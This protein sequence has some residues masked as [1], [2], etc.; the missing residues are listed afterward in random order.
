MGL[1]LSPARAQNEIVNEAQYG[2]TISTNGDPVKGGTKSTVV[3]STTRSRLVDPRGEVQGCN[4]ATL[5]NYTGF[6][7]GL[8]DADDT[9]PTGNGVKSLVP[10]TA[11]TPSD[12]ADP[13]LQNQNPYALTNATHGLFSFLLDPSRGQIAPGKTYL[14]ILQPP[15]GSAYR[16][17]RVRIVMQSA[18]AGQV[19]YTAASLDGEAISASSGSNSLVAATM[20]MSVSV[21]HPA[22]VG[23]NLTLSDCQMHPL[24]ITKIGDRAAAEPGDTVVYRVAVN[25]LSGAPL[26]N[27]Q[28]T[29]T[30]PEGF[31]FQDK[32]LRGAQADK[33]VPLKAVH[34]GRS[35]TLTA[36]GLTLATGQSLSV[37]YA[38]LV[39]P[40]ALRGDG[41]N[42]ASVA[43]QI[44]TTL[45]G[46]SATR[47][48]S[49]GPAVYAV[50]LN[51][52]ILTDTGT[53]V[54]RVFHDRNGDGEMQG[55]EPGISGAVVILDDSTRVVTDK[56]GLFSVP[57]V[58]AGYHMATLDLRSLPAYA[59]AHNRR[60]LE[61]NSPARLVH[62]E[63]G[64]LARVN[65]AVMPR[66]P[67]A[68]KP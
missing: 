56:N 8:Y 38:A 52:G 53:L 30:L 46:Q 11:T 6:S 29:D 25:N 41:R 39:T 64:G 43:G 33:S 63:P 60:F 28:I 55:G 49:D 47:A 48:V 51:Q 4:G 24:Q 5:P 19:S 20:P 1:A 44:T 14:L 10:L 3:G 42:S 62:L 12:G 17:R 58:S 67:E 23:L 26:T 27:I 13:N 32:S 45:A 16:Q 18:P 15:T 31:D 57:S 34:Q 36:P 2:Y 59:L 61:R 40:D 9:D 7:L 37:V 54:G 65:F 66:T 50:R 22:L 35:I 21:T 68:A